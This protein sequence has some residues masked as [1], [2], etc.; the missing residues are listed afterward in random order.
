M[1]ETTTPEVSA[2]TDAERIQRE[3]D[4]HNQRFTEETRLHQAK[5]YQAIKPITERFAK[6][7]EERARGA[8]VLEYGCA[9]GDR[10]LRLAPV[11]KSIVGIDISDVAVAQ[12]NAAAQAAGFTNTKFLVMNAEAMSFPDESFDVVFGCGI[13]HHLDVER[14]LTDVR[15]VLRPG[16]VAIFTEPLGHNWIINSYRGSTPEARTPDEHPLLKKDFAIADRIFSK[17]RI[18]YC[19]LTSIGAVFLAKTPVGGVA[20]KLA[21]AVDS[22]L[23]KLPIL[24]WQAWY[25][26]IEWSR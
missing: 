21:T 3:K 18:T 22:V 16:G 24:R 13:V 6:L 5:Y 20:M 9:K 25:T 14:A 4:F 8:D 1:I 23:L 12:G 11:A 15:R 17:K 2:E 26:L 10:S 19:G 7:V